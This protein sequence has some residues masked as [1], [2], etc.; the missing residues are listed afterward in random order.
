MRVAE[1][2]CRWAARDRALPFSPVMSFSGD[3]LELGAGTIIADIQARPRRAE[4]VSR[5]TGDVRALALL[6][7]AY[8]RAIP[9][10][11]LGHLD[12]AGQEWRRGEK[13]LAQI[14]LAL[15]GLPKIDP[16][17][18]AAYRLFMADALMDDG[19]APRDV[20]A[21]L[22]LDVG[23]IDLV[24]RL[25]DPREP[26]V[27]QGNGRPSGEWTVAGAVR[28]I[29]TRIRSLLDRSLATAE[30]TA[31]GRYAARF[32]HPVVA[33]ATAFIPEPT[34]SW[35]VKGRLP[36]RPDL[37]FEWSLDEGRLTLRRAVDG[38]DE[39]FVEAH[40]DHEGIFRDPSGR[41]LARLVDGH[42]IVDLQAATIDELGSAAEEAGSGGRK[43]EPKL[44]PRPMPDK[45][46]R[47]GDEKNAQYKK[48]LD[49]E[50]QIKALVNPDNPTP[51]AF[52][53]QLPNPAAGG[54]LVFYDD[55]Q[56]KL[57]IMF[58]YKGTG[59]EILLRRPGYF[60]RRVLAET[61][62]D[63]ATRQIDASDGR[64]VVWVFAE[65]SAEEFAKKIFQNDEKLQRI[66]TVWIP[67]EAA[68]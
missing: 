18:D 34:G 37:E 12:R 61:W 7:A 47:N 16:A 66:G 53:V 1:H 24:E 55:C 43:D 31:L 27:P 38:G 4:G 13:C 62:L 48:D 21:A 3:R 8:Q 54:K 63:Q 49:Y 60:M 19:V 57:V 22:D 20:L 58:E 64:P 44:C 68:K 59:Y 51:R 46:G 14:H 32:L 5:K 35:P 67:A 2:R 29:V 56:R 33:F 11:I 30:L 25:Y 45:K 42:L 17:D 50:D 23:A 9:A 10:T 65:K 39:A 52:G 26:R 6:S 40:L 15:A 36:G 41:P 28:S